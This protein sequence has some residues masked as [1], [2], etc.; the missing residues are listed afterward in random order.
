[1]PTYTALR[2]ALP[3]TPG[4][5]GQPEIEIGMLACRLRWNTG[6]VAVVWR[7]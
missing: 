2:G 6:N 3:R 1:M 4:Y 7:G 5:R